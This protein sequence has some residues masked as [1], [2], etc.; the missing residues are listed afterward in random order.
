MSRWE[1][2]SFFNFL[3]PAIPLVILVPLL[4]CHDFLVSVAF[5]N[6]Q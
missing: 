5:V 4:F 1:S 2:Q 6:K 3:Y